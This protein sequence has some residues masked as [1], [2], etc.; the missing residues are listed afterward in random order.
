MSDEIPTPEQKEIVLKD[1]LTGLATNVESEEEYAPSTSIEL[2]HE[3]VEAMFDETKIKMITD[4][5]ELEIKG[6]LKLHTLNQIIFEGRKSVISELCNEIMLLKVS[7]NRGGRRE[8]IKAIFSNSGA[9][10]FDE[11]TSRF[12]RFLG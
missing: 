11:G 4:L 2:T 3:I 8:M 1:L 9:G 7:K 12:K 6:L 10:D 5:T